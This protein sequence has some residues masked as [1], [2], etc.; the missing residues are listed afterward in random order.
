MCAVQKQ[1]KSSRGQRGCAANPNPSIISAHWGPLGITAGQS[2]THRVLLQGS[3]RHSN[4][5][6]GIHKLMGAHDYYANHKTSV[7]LTEHELYSSKT[8]N[9]LK[10]YHSINTMPCITYAV[11]QFWMPETIA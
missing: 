2:M 6:R 5:H 11:K 3:S 8:K 9:L 1:G 7:D 4:K 10:R